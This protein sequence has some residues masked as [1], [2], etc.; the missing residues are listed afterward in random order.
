MEKSPDAFRT[1]S[2]V[3]EW[4]DVPTHVLRFWESRF[5]QV[6][7]VKRAGGRR[8]YRPADMELLGGIK[9][10][11]HDDGMTIRGV[12]KILREQGVR[13]VISLSPPL[14]P[15]ARSGSQAGTGSG[16]SSGTG[17]QA[18]RITAPEDTLTPAAARDGQA[19]AGRWSYSDVGV[20]DDGEEAPYIDTDAEAARLAAEGAAPATATLL[21]FPEPLPSTP[22]RRA[23]ED[24]DSLLEDDADEETPDTETP[25]MWAADGAGSPDSAR[26]SPAAPTETP[27]PAQDED[28]QDGAE[29][30]EPAADVALHDAAQPDATLPD[31]ILPD[32]MAQDAVADAAGHPAATSPT[33]EDLHAEDLPDDALDPAPDPG[34]AAE[35]A[36]S[37]G[38]DRDAP[39]HGQQAAAGDRP[40]TAITLPEL[41]PDPTDDAD[42]G[43]PAPSA[44]RLRQL[45]RSAVLEDA[46][47]V[48]PLYRR[49][50][51]L[52]ESMASRPDAL[53]GR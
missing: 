34:P 41:A 9:R 32:E 49:L 39:R 6:K 42:L 29:T 52:R 45:P 37:D 18:G 1:I 7:P 28:A 5:T 43:L 4:L 14:D 21:P 19:S 12:Q 22:R 24:E 40:G 20:A 26:H 47:Q 3:A 23:A 30:E 13:H 44:A 17:R 46:A 25:D 35:P 27:A 31:A 16:T 8:Y 48:I 10:L 15:Q 53:D 11:L 2:E 51:A 50:R 36:V 33:P 38:T